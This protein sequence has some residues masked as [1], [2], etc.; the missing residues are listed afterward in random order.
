MVE[1]YCAY[2][3]CE[4]IDQGRCQATAVK[5]DPEQGCMTYNPLSGVFPGKRD[6][7]GD[8]LMWDR[9]FIDDDTFDEDIL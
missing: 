6:D 8:K 1:I 9:E 7:Q 3:D 2:D 4:S 5:I